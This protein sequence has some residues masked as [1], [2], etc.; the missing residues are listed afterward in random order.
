MEITDPR[1]AVKRLSSEGI[2]IGTVVEHPSARILSLEGMRFETGDAEMQFDAFYAEAFRLFSENG[3]DF[4]RH[5]VKSWNYLRSVLSNYA[6]FNRAR[7][8]AF[9]SIGLESGYPAGTGIDCLLS[10]NAEMVSALYAVAP[11]GKGDIVLRSAK[12]AKQCEAE[13]YGPKFSRAKVLEVP[14]R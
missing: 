7:N 8:R 12:S 11:V 10:G 5:T 14:L 6:A 3:F 4:A 2:R 9:V 1:I 13:S